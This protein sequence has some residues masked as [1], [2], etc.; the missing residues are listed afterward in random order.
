MIRAI[1]C[2]AAALFAATSLPAQ[3]YTPKGPIEAKYQADGPW[4]VTRSATTVACDREGRLRSD[5]PCCQ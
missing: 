5:S 3:T 4:A 2:A 1:L